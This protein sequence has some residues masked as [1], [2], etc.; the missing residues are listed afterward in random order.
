[1]HSAGGE[2]DSAAGVSDFAGLER[3]CA[4]RFWQQINV[5]NESNI[6]LLK[7]I[8]KSYYG[9]EIRRILNDNN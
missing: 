3:F 9:N 8:F 6:T 5:T 2:A 1:M 7:S 4:K